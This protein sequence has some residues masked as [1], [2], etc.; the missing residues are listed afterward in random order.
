[1]R[2]VLL[3]ARNDARVNEDNRLLDFQIQLKILFRVNSL[4]SNNLF[5]LSN[6]ILSYTLEFSW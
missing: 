5:I 3:T 6:S 4:M 1:M 2:R